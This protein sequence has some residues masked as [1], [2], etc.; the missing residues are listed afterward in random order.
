MPDPVVWFNPA[1]SKCRTAHGILTDHGIDAT[2]VDY[3]HEPQPSVD[4]AADLAAPDV[5][6]DDLARQVG[7]RRR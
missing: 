4:P 1:C 6:E 5:D 2:Y 3:L 7:R